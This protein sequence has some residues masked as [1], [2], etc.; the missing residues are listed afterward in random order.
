M[1]IYWGTNYNIGEI[2]KNF[3]NRVNLDNGNLV[4]LSGQNYR[5]GFDPVKLNPSLLMFPKAFKTGKV[6][7][8]FPENGLGD[9]TVSRNGTATYFDKSGI[10]RIAQINE[11]RLEF[12]PSNGQYQGVKVE[13]SA[14]NFI[15]A[16]NLSLNTGS[17]FIS[18][19][20]LSNEFGPGVNGFQLTQQPGQNI[21][22]FACI[23]GNG[24]VDHRSFNNLL[25]TF[26]IKNPT[27]NFFGYA[28]TGA[29][30]ERWIN[31]S[32]ISS[33]PENTKVRQLPN[34]TF[35][36]EITISAATNFS[37]QFSQFR[38]GMVSGVNQL[39]TVTG[40]FIIGGVTLLYSTSPI[41]S[42]SIILTSSS[43]STRPADIISVNVPVGVSEIIQTVNGVESIITTIPSTYQLPNGNISRIIMK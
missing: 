41:T 38:M 26:L 39:G 42:S 21:G 20:S 15:G 30:G 36:I 10:L 27:T 23:I 8:V 32:N 7:S 18:K 37:F 2:N 5:N 19:I 4:K 24:D 25:L 29:V 6:Y 28:I 31:L 17:A 9:F 43:S 40:S 16:N 33:N 14:T 35:L 11:P 1:A 3:E 13:P 34:N 22:Q 12:D